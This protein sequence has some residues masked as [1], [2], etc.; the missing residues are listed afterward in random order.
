MSPYLKLDL[1]NHSTSFIHQDVK[2]VHPIKTYTYV[3][4]CS[5]NKHLRIYKHE[6]HKRHP[7]KCPGTCIIE[8]HSDVMCV[9]LFSEDVHHCTRLYTP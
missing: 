5:Y 9:Y 6:L 4:L 3:V 1:Q 8:R 2:H 7:L